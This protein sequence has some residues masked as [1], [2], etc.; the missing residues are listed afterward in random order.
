MTRY[1]PQWEGKDD[2]T[3]IPPR[4][5]VRIFDRYGGR[6]N[7]CGRA[8]W[9]RLLPRYDHITALVN[10]G[11]N[12]EANIQLLCTECHDSKTKSD[13]AEKSIIYTK[14]ARRM[15]LRR[16]RLIPGSKGSGFRKKM[17]GTVIRENSQH[18]GQKQRK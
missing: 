7:V 6:C 9:G 1:V 4:V 18:I 14:R 5:K 16:V 10:G 17:D 12:A 8:I 11:R 3:E 2:D 13:V 15:K